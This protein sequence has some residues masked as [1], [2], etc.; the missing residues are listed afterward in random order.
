[1]KTRREFLRLAFGTGVVTAAGL[2]LP[3]V[4]KRIY[5]FAPLREPCGPQGG[6]LVPAEL[7]DLIRDDILAAGVRGDRLV[8]IEGEGLE[9]AGRNHTAL[10]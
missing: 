1:M 6:W 9:R 4:P 7:A 2:H 5:S 3:Y 8:C 10:S